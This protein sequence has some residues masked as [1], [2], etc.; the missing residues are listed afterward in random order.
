MLQQPGDDGNDDD[1]NND[2]DNNDNDNKEEE[3]VAGKACFVYML[4]AEPSGATYVGATVNVDHRLRQHNGELSGGAQATTMRVKRGEVWRRV[5]YVSGFPDWIAA[6]QF[7]WRWK[8]ISR[9]LGFSGGRKRQETE[10]VDR[11]RPRERRM[12]ALQQLL[13]LDRPTTK[14]HRYADWPSGGPQV[15]YE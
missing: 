13:S 6:L 4:E 3:S 1:G 11:R 8:Q 5:C 14:A 2:N 10:V 15:H 12:E 9:K 7:E